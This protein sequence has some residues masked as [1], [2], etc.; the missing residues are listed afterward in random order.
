MHFHIFRFLSPDNEAQD[1][2]STG[3]VFLPDR[4]NSM[5]IVM[6][7]IGFPLALVYSLEQLVNQVHTLSSLYSSHRE[8][9]MRL[10]LWI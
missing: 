5:L 2:P 3:R 4:I 8:L 7:A 10:L 9:P 6:L 1:I